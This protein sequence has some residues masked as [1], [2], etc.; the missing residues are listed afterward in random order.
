MYCILVVVGANY[1]A[2]I[3]YYLYPDYLPHR[4]LPPLFGASLLLVT[5]VWFLLGW[6][7]LAR[8]G[9]RAG[10]W[11]LLIF[12]LADVGFY[13]FNTVNQVA[14]GFAPLVH[15]QTAIRCSSQ[16][17]RLAISIWCAGSHLSSS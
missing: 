14:H 3:P 4:A 12:L 10:F 11:L 7:L 8:R 16:S 6:L 17:L 13:L 1:L 9:S 15:L 5:F 2:Q